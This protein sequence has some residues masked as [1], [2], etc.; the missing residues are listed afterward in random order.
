M[1]TR[2]IAEAISPIIAE[3]TREEQPVFVAAGVSND[4][5]A[6]GA[7]MF[8]YAR[9]AHSVIYI[10]GIPYLR[11]LAFLVGFSGMLGIARQIFT[12]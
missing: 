10:A 8:F 6:R 2:D 12:A 3:Y 7:T 4:A 9:V 5:T 11:T 1:N